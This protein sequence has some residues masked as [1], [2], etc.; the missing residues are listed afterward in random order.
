VRTAAIRLG[1]GI[2]L[3]TAP[4]LVLTVAFP[5]QRPTFFSVYALVV[6]AM[7]IAALVGA[8][9]AL[10]P[11]AW[12]RSPF[13]HRSE[14]PEQPLAIDELA[15]IDRLVVLGSANEYDLHY[16]LRPLLRE[17]VAERLRSRRG[18]VFDQDPERARDLLGDELWAVVRPDREVGGRRGPGAGMPA[19]ARFVD[20]LEAL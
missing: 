4:T 2:V 12:Q 20:R 16:R 3:A 13:D 7:A 6:G 8:F 11:P 14:R 5:A 9:R 19:L 18:V 10:R 15:R 17:L 1:C